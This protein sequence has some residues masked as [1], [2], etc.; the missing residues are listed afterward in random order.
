MPRHLVGFA[1]VL[2]VAAAL[3]PTPA[4]AHKLKVWAA[5]ESGARVEGYVYFPGGGRA[6]GAKVEVFGPDGKRLAECPTGEEG[7]FAFDAPYRCDLEFRADSG[8][9]HAASMTVSASEL[10]ET[11]PPYPSAGAPETPPAPVP[12]PSAAP[13][14][15]T[16]EVAP[17]GTSDSALARQIAQLREQLNAYEDKVRLHDV[18]GG[19][20]YIAGLAGVVFYFKAR[21]RPKT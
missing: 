9:G 2:A 14:A 5:V 3:A 19:I 15:A 1:I 10:P 20:G 17:G 4:Y 18:L 12:P 7:E 11:L 8:D 16:G 13:G 21:A 6:P